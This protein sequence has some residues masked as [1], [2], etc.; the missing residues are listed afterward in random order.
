[1]EAL[2][3][4]GVSQVPHLDLG[5]QPASSGGETRT[6][7]HTIN[8]RSVV[9]GA[10]ESAEFAQVNMGVRLG[11]VGSAEASQGAQSGVA[12]TSR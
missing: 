7:N 10:A 6:L 2:V 5:L 11:L 8:S 12:L 3:G 1:M 9:V 4:S